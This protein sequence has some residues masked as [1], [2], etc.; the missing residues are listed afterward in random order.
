MT[1]Y[2]PPLF[3]QAQL[4]ECIQADTH[5]PDEVG[6]IKMQLKIAQ[7]CFRWATLDILLLKE[8]GEQRSSTAYVACLPYSF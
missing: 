7:E 1:S 2:L 8:N 4:Q 6:W 5:R 3:S